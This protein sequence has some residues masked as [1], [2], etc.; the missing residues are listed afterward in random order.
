MN[1]VIFLIDTLQIESAY[2]LGIDN[3]NTNNNSKIIVFSNTKEENEKDNIIIINS[4]QG[5]KLEGKDSNKEFQHQNTTLQ[6]IELSTTTKSSSKSSIGAFNFAAVGDWACTSKTKDTVENIIDQNPELV[7]ALGDL[8]YEKG[9]KCWL[10]IIKPLKEKTKIVIGNHEAD[11]SKKL[12]TYM[13]AFNLQKQY[14]SF[15]YLSKCSFSSV[16]H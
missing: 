14:Y 7:L 15:N 8:S 9:A 13:K 6:N 4:L 2:A 12:K 1:V 3:N 16:V 5:V 11:S 10:K